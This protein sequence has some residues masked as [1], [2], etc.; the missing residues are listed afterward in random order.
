MSLLQQR[1]DM[2]FS[3]LYDNYAGA[4][5]G[6]IHQIVPESETANDVYRKFL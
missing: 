6:I 5:N 2:A 4:L 1:S 3:Y